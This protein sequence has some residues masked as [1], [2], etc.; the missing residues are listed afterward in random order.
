MTDFRLLQISDTHLSRVQP[1]FVENFERAVTHIAAVKPDL[2]INT[3][4][5]AINGPD[6]PDDLAFAGTCHDAIAVE[7]ISVPG[8]HD[9]GDN[10]GDGGHR[11]SQDVTIDR[12]ARFRDHFGADHWCRDA[13]AWRLIGLNCQLFGTG[14]NTEASQWQFA[15]DAVAGADGRPIAIFLH[16][17]PLQSDPDEVNRAPTRFLATSARRRLLGIT[18]LGR[19]KVIASGHIHQSRVIDAAGIRY[20]WCPSTA[21]VMPERK[22]PTIG[23]KHVGLTDYRFSGEDVSV[24]FTKPDGMT[25][26]DLSEIT[27][28][29]D[30]LG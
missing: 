22:Q 4:D 12:V 27:D 14:L 11:P 2:V 10:P 5:V 13:A 8:N 16:K 29:Y 28:S 21:F 17:P 18:T 19:V 6:R 26:V 24:A 3:G 1:H 7:V 23:V 9:I 30:K 25:S 15:E 20:V